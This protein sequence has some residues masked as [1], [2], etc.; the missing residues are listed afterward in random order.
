MSP[1]GLGRCAGGAQPPAAR[2][3]RDLAG[4]FALLTTLP[5]S[6]RAGG[7][8]EELPRCAPYF[9]LAG[10][11]LGA[12]LWGLD[13]ASAPLLGPL[14]RAALLML[15]L[16]ALTGGLHLDGLADTC[17]GLFSRERGGRA[18]EI[19]RQGAVGALGAAALVLAL[20]LRFAVYAS[21]E[22][23]LRGPSL[24][25]AA[26]AGR[27]AMVLAMA[28]FPAAGSGPGL[29]QAF[30]RKVG[31]RG[32]S[33]SLGLSLGLGAALWAWGWGP[34][35]PGAWAAAVALGAGLVVA[36]LCGHAVA[37]AVARRLG[38]LSGDVYGAVGEAAELAFLLVS[39]LAAGWALP[40]G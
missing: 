7:R 34:G 29:G 27:Q 28:A 9:P 30:A 21:L 3:W 31:L 38:G 40:A 5:V 12:A 8:E 13:W 24:V 26:V 32:V 36:L 23:G 20:L 4:A 15:A 6:P 25:V 14:L 35:V 2:P 18:L 33:A 19:M 11:A 1:R 39:A 10:A 17:D 16:F 37:R 22:G